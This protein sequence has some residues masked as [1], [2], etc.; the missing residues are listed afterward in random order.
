MMQSGDSL[1]QHTCTGWIKTFEEYYNDQT[2]K[3]INNVVHYL[4]EEPFRKFIWAEMSFLHLWWTRAPDSKRDLLTRLVQN[5]QFE[6]VTGGT[7]IFVLV[8]R[9]GC[10]IASC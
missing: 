5:G 6:I 10:D 3:I 8:F 1:T 7:V 2:E 4:S 9:I